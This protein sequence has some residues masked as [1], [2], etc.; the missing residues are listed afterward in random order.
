MIIH[1]TMQTRLLNGEPLNYTIIFPS[2]VKKTMLW[3]H[4]YN[5]QAEQILMQSHLETL[6]ETCHTAIVLPDLPDTYYF[7]QPWNHCYTERCLISEFLPFIHQTYKLPPAKLT[8]AGASMGGFGCLLLGSRHPNLFQKIICISGAF[9]LDDL[10]IGNP[11]VTGSSSNVS[12]FQNLFGDFYSLDEDPSR[13][14]FLAASLALQENK[15][16]PVFMACGRN[17]ML[18]TRNIRLRD[19]LLAL[20]ADLTWNETDGDHSWNCFN[21]LLQ[22]FCC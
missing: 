3:L 18:Y 11:E 1:H 5:E 7:D 14:P 4:G 22:L 10:L 6:A 9:I 12:H 21:L 8:I 17:D 2:S 15:L 19:R 20:G 13:N 16:P